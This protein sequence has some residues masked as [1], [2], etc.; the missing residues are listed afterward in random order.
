MNAYITYAIIFVLLLALELLY[1]RIADRC[2]IIDKPN[3]RS[4]HSK[5]V[6]RGGGVIFTLGFWVWSAFFGFQYPWALAAVTMAAGISFV[7]D[8]HSLPDS[9]RLVVQL[10]A[11]L[12]L[13]VE[14]GIMQWSMWWV[15]LIALFVSVGA[16][17]IIN[18]MDG[19]NG[20]MGGYSLAVI[21]PVMIVN[22]QAALGCGGF[23]TFGT[24]IIDHTFLNV[25]ALSLIVFCLF[26]FRPKNKAKCFAGDVGSVGIAFILL[27]AIG[28][29]IARTGDVTYLTFLLVYGVDGCLTIIHRIMLHEH[30]GEAHRKHMYQLMSNELR[31][32]HPV[33]SLIYMGVQ[34]AV[35]LGFV[36]V[37]PLASEAFGI[38]LVACHWIYLAVAL[39]ILAMVYLLFMKKYYHLHEEYLASI[40]K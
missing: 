18:F 16:T 40:K 33:V 32:S 29:L 38:G 9:V 3:E 17:N 5:I 21:V 4:S 14:L 26:N 12:L 22:A 37:C 35:S 1:F 31:M 25:V 2:N 28:M 11:M 7:D 39:V 36:F 23:C 6:L 13:F 30:L 8:V 27:F 15:V 24:E 20:I 19:I 10:V 34:L